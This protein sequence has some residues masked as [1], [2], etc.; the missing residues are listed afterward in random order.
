MDISGKVPAPKT[1]SIQSIQPTAKPG[2]P[3]RAADET[4]PAGDRVSLSAQARELAA[5]RQAIKAMP[6]VRA[7]KVAEVKARL[8]NGTYAVDADD[9]AAKMLTESLI[10]DAAE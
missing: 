9:I 7:D 1:A 2:R 5:A 8:E 6:E 10:N 3:A 4:Q